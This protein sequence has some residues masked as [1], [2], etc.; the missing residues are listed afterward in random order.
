[1]DYGVGTG[2]G[3]ISFTGHNLP[4]RAK[5]RVSVSTNGALTPVIVTAADAGGEAYAI[6]PSILPV[7]PTT[8]LV[9]VTPA[10][11]PEICNGLPG[12]IPPG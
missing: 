5:V 11:G 9:C 4:A 2:G 8:F 3:Q 12:N 6:V 7:G 1:M 10:V